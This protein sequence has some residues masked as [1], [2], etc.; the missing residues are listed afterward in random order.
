MLND[1]LLPKL[2]DNGKLLISRLEFSSEVILIP[3]GSVVL[4]NEVSSRTYSLPN[5]EPGNPK[6]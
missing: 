1:G 3:K 5:L 4:E 6:R 2:P